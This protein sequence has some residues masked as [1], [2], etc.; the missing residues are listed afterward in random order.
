VF[1]V[2]EL[3]SRGLD[4]RK[5]RQNAED[6]AGFLRMFS[7]ID[8]KRQKLLDILIGPAAPARMGWRDVPLYFAKVV[9]SIASPDAR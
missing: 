9:T 6:W 5:L 2:Q 4:S 8:E 3:H 7:G 1:V